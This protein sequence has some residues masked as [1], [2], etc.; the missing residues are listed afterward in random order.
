MEC[1]V[2]GASKRIGSINYKHIRIII[3]I[4]IIISYNLLLTSGYI[5]R[6]FYTFGIKFC[7]FILQE[8]ICQ[9]SGKTKSQ[10]NTMANIPI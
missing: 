2:I 9:R 6:A 8:C 5:C 1:K 7:I 10:K 3:V 4:I